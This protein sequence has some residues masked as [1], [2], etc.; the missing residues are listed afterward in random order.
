MCVSAS[1]GSAHHFSP[2]ATMATTPSAIF[3]YFSILTCYTLRDFPQS[4]TGGHR[5]ARTTMEV[6]QVGVRNQVTNARRDSFFS[7]FKQNDSSLLQCNVKLAVIYRRPCKDT[8]QSLREWVRKPRHKMI[9]ALSLQEYSQEAIPSHVPYGDL[10]QRWLCD[11]P[12]RCV[13]TSQ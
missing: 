11:K 1:R 7:H 4:H 12:E 5:R 2:P 10:V 8:R 3:F 9:S 6:T 13:V